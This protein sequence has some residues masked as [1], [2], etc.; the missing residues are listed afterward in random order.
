MVELGEY[1]IQGP[2]EHMATMNRKV[3]RVVVHKDYHAPTFENDIAILELESP[4]E[5]KPHI[6][7]ICLPKLNEVF[8]GRT[9]IVSGWGRLEY[10]EKT[11][12]KISCLTCLKLN[13]LGG[14]VPSILH[15]VSVPIMNN[16]RCQSMFTTSGHK[17]KVRD[18]FLCA[19]Y[20]E[21]KKDSCEVRRK[22]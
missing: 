6:V 2:T 1:D 21:G 13:I 22:H 20:Q 4:I 5:R 16:T 11:K 12:K 18:S 3:K 9:A 8:E 19:G 17:K 14:N 10:G 15:Q 7:P